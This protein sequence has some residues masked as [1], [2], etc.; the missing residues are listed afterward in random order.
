MA[1]SSNSTASRGGRGRTQGSDKL[2]GERHSSSKEL[3]ANSPSP[4][5]AADL[6]Y[7]EAQSALELA[8]AQLQA[9]DLPVEEMGG[10]YQRAQAYAQRCED[11]LE[12]IEQSIELWD[13]QDG[14]TT[15]FNN[16]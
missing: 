9:P 15:P 16:T 13:P 2:S 11:L 8:L 10:L 14:T 6:S 1:R 7:S 5:I 12:S 3:Q 4:P